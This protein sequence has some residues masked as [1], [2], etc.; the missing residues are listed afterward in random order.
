M[1][2]L[3]SVVMFSM[4]SGAFAVKLAG[5]CLA[6]AEYDQGVIVPKHAFGFCRENG[7]DGGEWCIS[8]NLCTRE[9]NECTIVRPVGKEPYAR[10]T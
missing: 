3:T 4:L 2:F 6:I 5:T 1:K 9:N 8:R 7:G 10:C